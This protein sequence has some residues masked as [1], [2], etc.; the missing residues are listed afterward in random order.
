MLGMRVTV[1]F[2]ASVL[3][4]MQHNSA[5]GGLQAHQVMMPLA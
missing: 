5:V 3:G 4:M 2:R 1:I